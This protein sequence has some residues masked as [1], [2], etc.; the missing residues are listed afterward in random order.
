MPN[1]ISELHAFF[2]AIHRKRRI[3]AAL[4]IESG[5]IVNP[6]L[7]TKIISGLAITLLG[8]KNGQRNLV[9]VGTYE[10][11]ANREFHASTAY[12]LWLTD[13][14]EHPTR[15]GNVYRCFVQ[16][17]Y[18]R[19]LVGW[20]IDRNREATLVSDALFVAARS[21]STSPSTVIR[22]DHGSQFKL[23]GF[24]ENVHQFGLLSV[25]IIVD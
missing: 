17:I 15:E 10:D 16:D 11:L 5:F 1:T 13:I 9:D 22:S 24:S 2:R 7:I 21:R 14:T 12:A 4:A 23:W 6:K 3:R 18:S 20:A 25:G 19:K 8:L